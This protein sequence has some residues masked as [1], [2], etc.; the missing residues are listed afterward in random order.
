MRNEECGMKNEDGCPEPACR[1][2]MPSCLRLNKQEWE[3][4]PGFVPRPMKF[5]HIR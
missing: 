1:W 3:G 4:S 2:F 5:L